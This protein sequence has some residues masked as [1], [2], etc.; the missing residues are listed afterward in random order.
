MVMSFLLAYLFAIMAAALR[1]TVQIVGFALQIGI[2]VSP[3][4]FPMTMFPAAWR[5]VLWI[6]P[7]TPVVSGWQTI[8]LQGAWPAWSV[9]IA[10]ALWIAGAAAL[11]SVAV[12]RS[13]DQL[14]DW[15]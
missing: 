6:N 3:V 8:L 4:L 10:L 11:L 1:D 5:W 9:W 14:V 12:R 7:M 2:F 13:H 15:L